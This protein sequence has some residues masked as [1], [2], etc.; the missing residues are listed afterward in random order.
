LHQTG[1]FPAQQSCGCNCL[2]AL[3]GRDS[4]T[5]QSKP[6]KTCQTSKITKAWT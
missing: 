2:I 6:L 4:N 3:C 5:M 1:K